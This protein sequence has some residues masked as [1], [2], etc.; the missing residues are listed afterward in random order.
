MVEIGRYGFHAEAQRAEE[1]QRKPEKK[2]SPSCTRIDRLELATAGNLCFGNCR[3]GGETV[4]G[5]TRT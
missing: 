3:V 4:C 5:G 2:G 1:A